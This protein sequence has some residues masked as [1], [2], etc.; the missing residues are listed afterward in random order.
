[1]AQLAQTRHPATCWSCWEQGWAR[2]LHVLLLRRT[3][4]LE[5]PNMTMLAYPK[6]SK[7]PSKSWPLGHQVLL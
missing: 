6:G 1:M 5:E 7:I 3:C 4:L 2:D